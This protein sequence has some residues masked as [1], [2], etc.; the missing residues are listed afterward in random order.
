[1]EKVASP[2]PTARAAALAEERGEGAGRAG[3][4]AGLEKG[5]RQSLISWTSRKESPPSTPPPPR[6]NE[7]CLRTSPAC[8]GSLGEKNSI[9]CPLRGN[10]FLREHNEDTTSKDTGRKLGVLEFSKNLL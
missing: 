2:I 1:M 7:G 4:P 6:L 8:E 3:P 10:L 5:R 9:V